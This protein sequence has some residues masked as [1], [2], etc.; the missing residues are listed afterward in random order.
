M[1]THIMREAIKYGNRLLM[2][3]DGKIILDIK[4]EEK[5]NL[6]TTQLLQYF[7]SN[8]DIELSDKMILS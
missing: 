2:L 8:G 5:K 7:E 6:T 1:I 3:N 4:G